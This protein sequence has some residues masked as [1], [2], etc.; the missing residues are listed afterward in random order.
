MHVTLIIN[1]LFQY[2]N[3]Y[4]IQVTS[5]LSRWIE[6]TWINEMRRYG[7]A[8]IFC[9]ACGVRRISHCLTVFKCGYLSAGLGW[10]CPG[11]DKWFSA[12]YI[13]LR[14][15]ARPYLLYEPVAMYY[16]INWPIVWLGSPRLCAKRRQTMKKN[17]ITHQNSMVYG[18]KEIKERS[19]YSGLR[20]WSA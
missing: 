16:R 8:Q 2:L 14:S 20:C 10:R 18:P 9:T 15:S 13:G 17:I 5:I 3:G 11:P 4:L 7:S 12:Q 19:R 1:P 6:F